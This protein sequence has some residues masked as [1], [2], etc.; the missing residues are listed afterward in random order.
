MGVT[1]LV[2]DYGRG[3][4]TKTCLQRAADAG[5]LSGAAFLPSE[6]LAQEKAE[7]MVDKN[8]DMAVLDEANYNN[9][10][11][12]YIVELRTTIPTFFMR[13][14]GRDSMEIYADATAVTNVVVG[15][16]NGGAF[17]YAIINPNLNLDPSDDLIPNNYGRP[18]TIGYGEDN[19]IVGDWSNGSGGIP[20][21]NE[22]NG[23]GWRGALSLNDDGTYGNG[24]ASDLK[25]AIVDGWPGTMR[26]GDEAPIQTGNITSIDQARTEM[27][28]NNPMDFDDFDPHLHGDS[29]RI[30][31]VP[32]VHLINETRRDTYTVQDYNNGAAWDHTNIVVDGFAPFF[33]LDVQEQGDVDG[34]GRPRDRDWITGYFVPNVTI[35]NYLPPNE[36][37]NYFG[38]YATPRLSR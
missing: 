26:T 31:F 10:G 28:G 29:S 24:G 8:F 1:G 12:E 14:F 15:G 2:I 4:W 32:I 19:V 35:N 3:V 17:P 33:V 25:N 27:L 36:N 16:M 30:V 18:Y 22:G 13:I 7:L 37:T 38:V 6:S 34:D 5:A 9:Q 20:E 23:R 11:N 21:P